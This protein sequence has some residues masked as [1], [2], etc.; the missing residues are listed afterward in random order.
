MREPAA[1]CL[2]ASLTASLVVSLRKVAT[3]STTD[4]VTVG[5]RSDM[6]SK[7]PLSSGITRARARAAPVEVGIMLTPAVRARRR[8]LCTWSRMR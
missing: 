6:P 3:K 1:A 7:R 2:K 5:T 8:S 4:T